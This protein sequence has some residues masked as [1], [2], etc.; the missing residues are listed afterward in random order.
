MQTLSFSDSISEQYQGA[1]T[2]AYMYRIRSNGELVQVL[3]A[4]GEKMERE[5]PGGF[6]VLPDGQ[7]AAK[8]FGEE[9]AKDGLK[10]RHKTR[11]KTFAKWPMTSVNAGVNPEQIDEL[12]SFWARNGVK[13]CD[14]MPNGDVVWDS[15]AARKKDCEARSLYDRNGGYSDPQ[16]KHA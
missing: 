14:V 2:V 3:M 8:A 7:E 4:F 6:I 11:R 10:P 1:E 15:P 9:L 16:P 12:R 13:G 5:K